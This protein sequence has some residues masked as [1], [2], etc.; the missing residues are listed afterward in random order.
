MKSIGRFLQLVGLVVLPLGMFLE[1]SGA[2]GQ[3]FGLSQML[4]MLVFGVLSFGLGRYL[5]GYART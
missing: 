4:I 1:L 3:K 2:L 5:E